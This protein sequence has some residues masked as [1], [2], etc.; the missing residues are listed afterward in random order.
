MCISWRKTKQFRKVSGKPKKGDWSSLG[1]MSETQT[2]EKNGGDGG[3]EA[4][5]WKEAVETHEVHN[6]S[7]E[8]K[9]N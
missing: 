1:R 2:S 4:K 9:K 7:Y 8:K 6:G 5:R 3:G